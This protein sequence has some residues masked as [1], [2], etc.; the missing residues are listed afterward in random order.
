[1]GASPRCLLDRRRESVSFCLQ[2]NEVKQVRRHGEYS[3]LE[4]VQFRDGEGSGP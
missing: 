4:A 1:M 3:E 2:K